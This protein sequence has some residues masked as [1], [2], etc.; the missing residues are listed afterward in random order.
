M[1]YAIT[2]IIILALVILILWKDNKN[3]NFMLDQAR[4]A[5]DYYAK[6]IQEA[7]HVYE[8]STQ[9]IKELEEKRIFVEKFISAKV[10]ELPVVAMAVASYQTAQDEANEIYLR[11]KKYPAPYAADMLHRL[12]KEKELLIAKNKAFEWEKS[13]WR[14]IIKGVT[15]KEVPERILQYEATLRGKLNTLSIREKEFAKSIQEEKE[16]IRQQIIQQMK[17]DQYKIAEQERMT[18]YHLHLLEETTENEINRRMVEVE[19][20]INARTKRIEE[21]ERLVTNFISAKIS[22]FPIVATVISDYETAKDELLAYQLETKRR[23]APAKAEEIRRIKEEKRALI[24]QNRAYKWELEYLRQILPWL[25]DLE[26]RPLQS[27]PDTINPNFQKEDAAGYWLTPE[28]YEKLSTVDKYQLALDRYKKR[29]KSNAEIGR[30]YERYIGYL[31]EQ[32]GYSVRYFGIEQGLEDLGRDLI[33]TKGS[34]TLIIQC[35]CWSNLKK[36]QIHENHINQLYGTTLVHRIES[37]LGARIETLSDEQIDT[38][39]QTALDLCDIHPVFCSTVPYSKTARAFAN[40][41]G[42][43]CR[44]V[45]LGEY[46]MIKCNISRRDG[47]CIY[48][49]PFDQQYDRCVITPKDGEFYAMTVEEAENK[50]FRRALRWHSGT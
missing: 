37:T 23:P 27:A 49:L 32:D 20:E 41:L 5:D 35:K 9:K 43:T 4:K 40:V 36:K 50:G 46:P 19:D 15:L 22:D 29:T 47:E 21:K 31:Y 6:R 11:R 45:P 24:A 33:C 1:G 16:K 17:K 26:D 30:D 2:V 44:I 38:T 39:T 34:E 3:L 8:D 25:P 13:H 12:R 14:E 42:I 28:E 10:S 48:H 18:K 7:N